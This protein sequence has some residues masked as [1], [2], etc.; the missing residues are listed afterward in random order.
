MVA[1]LLHPLALLVSKM[2][3]TN[4]A[5]RPVAD[6]EIPPGDPGFARLIATYNRMTTAVEARADVERRLAERERYV[7]LGRLSSSLAHEINNPLG[8]LLNAADTHPD[9]RRPARSGAAVRRPDAAGLAHL[10]DVA[11]AI[12]DQNRL[13]RAGQPLGP[14]D[15]EDLQ[16]LFEP[17][18]V[19][20]DQVLELAIEV[21]ATS[22]AALPAAPVRQLALNLLLN[23]GAAAA[24]GGRV[25]LTASNGAESLCRS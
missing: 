5:P 8:G 10:R 3:D 11:R 16:L 2:D 1:R 13:D 19:S 7:S 14:E 20:R 12:L 24:Q 17:E 23:A 21:G 25:G 4:G 9:L 15:F 18:A 22:L 6:A